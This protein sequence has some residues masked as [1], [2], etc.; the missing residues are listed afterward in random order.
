MDIL[1]C[2]KTYDSDSHKPNLHAHWIVIEYNIPES[3]HLNVLSF[4]IP[5]LNFAIPW[6]WTHSGSSCWVTRQ[7]PHPTLKSKIILHHLFASQKI[8][9]DSDNTE[10][11]VRRTPKET[12]RLVTEDTM[13]IHVGHFRVLLCLCF[14]TSLSMKSFIWKWVLHAVSFSCK[15]KPF[16]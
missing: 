10:K 9:K 16:S 15:S 6:P 14:K 7:A 13:E 1:E 11:G 8:T 4:K 5:E 2:Y 12:T 3:C